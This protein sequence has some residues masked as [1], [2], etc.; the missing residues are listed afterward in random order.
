VALA[1]AFAS[2]ADHL[3]MPNASYP[4]ETRL[5]LLAANKQASDKAVDTLDGRSF[6]DNIKATK[7]SLTSLG[8]DYFSPSIASW[9]GFFFEGK[10]VPGINSVLTFLNLP[11]IIFTQPTLVVKPSSSFTP[12]SLFTS[13]IAVE[14]F[15]DKIP[16]CKVVTAGSLCLHAPTAVGFFCSSHAAMIPQLSANLVPPTLTSAVP[17]IAVPAFFNVMRVPTTE[18]FAAARPL[19]PNGTLSSALNYSITDKDRRQTTPAHLLAPAKLPHFAAADAI[20]PFFPAQEGTSVEASF[21]NALASACVRDQQNTHGTHTLYP[22]IADFG[23]GAFQLACPAEGTVRNFITHNG[24]SVSSLKYIFPF[25]SR[26]GIAA[27]P[28]FADLFGPTSCDS[29]LQ[30]YINLHPSLGTPF[31]AMYATSSVFLDLLTY[32]RQAFTN[33][34]SGQHQLK[35]SIAELIFRT[36]T[37]SQDLNPAI[38]TTLIAHGM[39]LR[40]IINQWILAT[41]DTLADQARTELMEFSGSTDPRGVHIQLSFVQAFRNLGCNP[42]VLK[43]VSITEIKESKASQLASLLPASSVTPSFTISKTISTPEDQAR[44][45]I[46]H[47]TELARG[48]TFS[49]IPAMDVVAIRTTLSGYGQFISR[50]RDSA[51]ASLRSPSHNPSDN[52]S[53]VHTHKGSPLRGYQP[54][55]ERSSAFEESSPKRLR[56]S[57]TPPPDRQWSGPSSQLSPSLSNDPRA[58]RV[59]PDNRAWITDNYSRLVTR[60]RERLP[61]SVAAT[62]ESG[63]TH[64]LNWYPPCL[65]RIDDASLVAGWK[66]IPIYKLFPTCRR[67]REYCCACGARGEDFHDSEQCPMIINPAHPI[68][69]IPKMNNSYQFEVPLTAGH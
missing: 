7:L 19:Q 61:A 14:I 22:F 12:G 45:R 57:P 38:T 49:T 63:I 37:S 68:V 44:E 24:N 8:Q 1:E 47:V 16:L 50:S 28:A 67:N 69:G 3:E 36:W 65:E 33:T 42:G 15:F 31:L 54:S 46:K 11:L 29:T 39:H 59:K 9:L 13:D 60:A 56:S 43:L 23:A 62:Y 51:P 27:F 10:P 18:E 2:I 41:F 30:S 64:R 5:K 34:I 52:T 4:E 55:P 32:Y 66:A 26:F 20:E 48:K 35:P 17:T 53:K 21:H 6:V 25:I 58:G 40:F